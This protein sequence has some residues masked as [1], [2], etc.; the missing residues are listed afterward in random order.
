MKNE[1]ELVFFDLETT[2]L[3]A[4]T[5]Q[6]IEI[7][8]VKVR[9]GKEI[10]RFEQ[11]CRLSEGARLPEFISALTGITPLDLEPAE[12]VDQVVDE[13]LHFAGRS[14]LLAHNSSFDAGFLRHA[15]QGKLPNSVYDTLE[16]ARIFFPTLQSHSLIALLDSLDIKKE[17]AHRAL[18]DA[19]SLFRFYRKLKDKIAQLA[20]PASILQRLAYLY[21]AVTELG[22]IEVLGPVTEEIKAADQTVLTAMFHAIDREHLPRLKTLKPGIA[23]SHPAPDAQ[24]LSSG[25]D[26]LLESSAKS[27]QGRYLG[28]LVGTGKTCTILLRTPSALDPLLEDT[29]SGSSE[30]Q[31][32]L[33]ESP[34]DLVCLV[35]LEHATRSAIMQR[36]FGFELAALLLYE[37]ETHSVFIPDMPLFLKKSRLMPY[38]SAGYCSQGAGCSCWTICPLRE[39]LARSSAARFHVASLSDVPYVLHAFPG[40]A[41]LLVSSPETEKLM[42]DVL[43]VPEDQISS[44]MLR[45]I[46]GTAQQEPGL[47]AIADEASHAEQLLNDLYQQLALQEKAAPKGRVALGESIWASTTLTD[48]RRAADDL[49]AALGKAGEALPPSL[50]TTY[51]AHAQTLAS[52]LDHDGN[53]SYAVWMERQGD[54]I[55]LAGSPATLVERIQ[56]RQTTAQFFFAGTSI[57]PSGNR[58]FLPRMLGF[59]S[60]TP[61]VIVQETPHEEQRI[62]TFVTLHLPKP[63]ESG[64]EKKSAQLIAETMRRFPGKAAVVSNSLETLRRMQSFLA[65]EQGL[66]EYE[67]LLPKNGHTRTQLLQQFADQDKAILL[68]PF[69]YLSFGDIVPANFLFVTKLQFP[70]SFLPIVTRL[71]QLFKEQKIDAFR[72]F[73]LPY[74]LAL[75]QYTLRQMDPAVL[76]AMFILDNRSFSATYADRIRTVLPTPALFLPVEN[77]ENLLQ[78]LDRWI[79]NQTL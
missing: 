53:R 9:N 2:G 74:A 31:W 7:G 18:G 52:L 58:E 25:A 34:D 32:I 17:E 63:N 73:D 21:P 20:L 38:V 66:L 69:D 39:L 22:L 14:P 19:L 10:A 48:L 24:L 68:I 77:Q 40:D 59:S 45:I 79:R 36:E 71:K 62:P 16:L 37:R 51:D 78:H 76:R 41:P 72:Q 67:L 46:A 61:P 42:T 12:P 43:E 55:L 15:L 56:L 23:I 30:P 1:Q 3:D 5:D 4:S 57:C 33:Q 28:D 29:P 54:E 35:Q 13:F 49:V 50:R 70:N 60:S 11:F 65:R 26:V 44:T 47:T 27:L 64:F 8:A 75:L 6:I